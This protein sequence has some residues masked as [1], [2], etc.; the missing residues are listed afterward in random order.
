MPRDRTTTIIIAGFLVFAVIY[1][2]R[3]SF[4]GPRYKSVVLL[5]GL[6][7]ALAASRLLGMR[8]DETMVMGVLFAVPMADQIIHIYGYPW[9]VIEVLCLQVMTPL[10]LLYLVRMGLPPA[11]V[12]L[13]LGN[14]MTTLKTTAILLSLAGAMSVIGLLF[15]SMT[16]YYPIWQSG[17]DVTPGEFIYHEAI[18]AIMMFGGEFFYRG[19]VLFTLARRSFW[20][21]I[22]LQSLPYA[23]LHLG[24][25]AVEVPYSLV[26]G[27]I[28]GWAN[29]RSRSMLP[30]WVTHFVGSALFDALILLT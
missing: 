27:I 4:P 15:P 18:I 17:S 1:S 8:D 29:L 7:G 22:L 12:G 3:V 20:G 14:R 6:L 25:P 13:S 16:N 5:G 9:R 28:F 19:L 2:L 21:A 24:K 26:A 23:F 10:T 11:D 30:S